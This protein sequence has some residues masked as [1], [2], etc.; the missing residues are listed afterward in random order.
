MERRKEKWNKQVKDFPSP[1]QY[2]K[3]YVHIQ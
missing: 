2:L 1:Y 3:D